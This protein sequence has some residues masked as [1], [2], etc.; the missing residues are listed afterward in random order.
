MSARGTSNTNARGSAAN[1]RNLTAWML[2]TFGDGTTCLC[3]FGCGT[4]L[5][6]T[7]LTKD[8]YPIPGRKGGRYVRGNVRPACGHCNSVHGSQE[9][10]RE[11]A[12]AKA[13]KEARNAAARARY[14]AKK[15]SPGQGRGL[16][17]V[18]CVEDEIAH[19]DLNTRGALAS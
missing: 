19:L 13:R 12:Q 6:A 9:A 5:D 8:R 14:A 17:L 2:N 3:A 11:R 15:A 4:V 16:P 18:G 1:R 7:T 10:A